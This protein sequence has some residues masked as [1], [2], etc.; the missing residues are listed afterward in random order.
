VLAN[1]AGT[2]R[3]VSHVAINGGTHLKSFFYGEIFH[4]FFLAVSY[5]IF[6]Y[7]ISYYIALLMPQN[8]TR[9]S[10]AVA[11]QHPTAV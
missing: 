2:L 3:R 11:V 8:K 1:A 9:V 7:F 10:A 5:I 6:I 4:T